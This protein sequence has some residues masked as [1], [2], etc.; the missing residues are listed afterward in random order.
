[1]YIDEGVEEV[2]RF[3]DQEKMTILEWTAPLKILFYPGTG[4]DILRVLQKFGGIVDRFYF[5]DTCE[6]FPDFFAEL[7][8][9]QYFSALLDDPAITFFPSS[10]KV[11]R[12]EEIEYLEYTLRYEKK[13]IRFRF[14][15]GDHTDAMK[16]MKKEKVKMDFLVLRGAGGEGG[17]NFYDVLKNSYQKKGT[18]MVTKYDPIRGYSST[19]WEWIFIGGWK[20]FKSVSRPKIVVERY[21]GIMFQKTTE[22]R[23]NDRVL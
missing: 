20:L 10:K 4:K 13:R 18:R 7:Q 6:P 2:V 8:D 17:S 15:L 23:S 9:T 3:S 11:F 19:N 5:N 22:L 1:M 16:H 12:T 14:Y 21:E